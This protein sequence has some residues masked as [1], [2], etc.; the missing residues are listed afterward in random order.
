[1]CV[2]HRLRVVLLNTA[3][4]V[5]HCAIEHR[6]MFRGAQCIHADM[7]KELI[8]CE[9]TAALIDDIVRVSQS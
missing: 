4:G 2:A 7:P 9:T 3:R 5:G 6:C 8:V 1:M